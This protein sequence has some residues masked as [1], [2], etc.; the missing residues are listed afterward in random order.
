MAGRRPALTVTV[1]LDP[2]APTPEQGSIVRDGIAIERCAL[3]D[4][5]ERLAVPG[6]HFV[7]TPRNGFTASGRPVNR[8]IA[9]RQPWGHGDGPARGCPP[10]TRERAAARLARSRNSSARSGLHGGPDPALGR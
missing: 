3:A 6:D 2:K 1:A 9:R 5:R 4:K 8:K 7:Q 10:I